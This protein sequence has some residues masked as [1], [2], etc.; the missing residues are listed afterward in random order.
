MYHI[1]CYF[2]SLSLSLA[3]FLYKKKALLPLKKKLYFVHS[4]FTLFPHISFL[5]YFFLKKLTI[6]HHK[7]KAHKKV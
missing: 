7:K 6:Y 2:L 5:F 4:I 3:L 1:Y